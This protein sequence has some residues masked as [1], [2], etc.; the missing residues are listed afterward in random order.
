MIKTTLSLK[1]DVE[2]EK[3]MSGREVKIFNLRSKN[4]LY[5][6]S[7]LRTPPSTKF[8]FSNHHD[9]FIYQ[10]KY[11]WK[12]LLPIHT[13]VCSFHLHEQIKRNLLTS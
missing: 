9:H 3:N 5:W 10:V 12:P 1:L 7:P 2:V 13:D 6:Q 11:T 4:N 8:S